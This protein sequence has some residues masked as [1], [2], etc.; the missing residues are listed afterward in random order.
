M[1]I[2]LLA[3]LAFVAAS[4]LVI[5]LIL[6]AEARGS[7][8]RARIRKRITTVAPAQGTTL[9]ITKGDALYSAVP[10]LQRLL[11][12]TQIARKLDLL[13]NQANINMSVGLFSLLSVAMAVVA[14][15][16]LS[17]MF[18][19]SVELA[20]IGALLTA[21]G[22]YLYLLYL[23]RKRIRKFL[24]Q[25]PDGLDIMAQGLQAGLG[26]SQSQL[27]VA[28]EMPD[29]IGTEFSIFM[30]ELNLGLPLNGA[31]NNFQ[32]RIPIPETRLFS[33]ALTVQRDVGGSLAELLNKLSDVIRERFRIERE[34]KTLTAQNRMAAVVV[35]SIP[36][37][38]YIAM[39]ILNPVLMQE[40]RDNNFGWIML[41]AALVLEVLGMFWFR[42][43]L[44]LHI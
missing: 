1:T 26:L 14:Y 43:L 31:L 12:Q 40:V 23:A 19:Q 13:L 44:R 37:V 42:R 11:S 25:M 20:L 30:E 16:V 6:G 9:R 34:I 5:A 10:Q 29:P 2:F 35:C 18:T 32:E 27:Y 33:T 17:M 28:K 38:L 22:P 21:I 4:S 7:S 3:I 8:P 39:S 41:M 24:E 15:T 36:P